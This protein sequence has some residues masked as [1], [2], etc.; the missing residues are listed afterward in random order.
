MPTPVSSG[1]GVVFL[2]LKNARPSDIGGGIGRVERHRSAV[3]SNGALGVAL[4]DPAIAAVGVGDGVP[5]G[6]RFIF[7]G[8]REILNGEVVAVFQVAHGSAIDVSD[9]AML[10]E[11][12]RIVIVDESAID[13]AVELV[14]KAS[15]VE[16]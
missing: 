1:A 6:W 14:G 7:N 4:H 8:V 3:V 11:F 16:G 13:I 12:D 15:V 5:V 10:I 9:R 2:T